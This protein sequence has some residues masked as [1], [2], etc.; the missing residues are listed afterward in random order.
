MRWADL[1]G[2]FLIGAMVRWL[3]RCQCQRRESGLVRGEMCSPPLGVSTD[4]HHPEHDDDDG[5]F[6]IVLVSTITVALPPFKQAPAIYDPRCPV[7][8][9][10]SLS[11]T[12]VSDP[13]PYS[14]TTDNPH[15]APTTPLIG[16]YTSPAKPLPSSRPIFSAQLRPGHTASMSSTDDIVK[17]LF[18]RSPPPLE[19]GTKVYDP[20]LTPV[21]SGLKEH[22]YVK[23]GE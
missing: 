2:F 11:R 13:S 14:D 16:R 4:D 9:T 21:I 23:A 6:D 18:S 7:C 1:P 15:R 19:P 5:S 22:K 17:K 3:G 8:T 10:T 20:S 12:L